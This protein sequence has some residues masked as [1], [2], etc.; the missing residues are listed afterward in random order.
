[1]YESDETFGEIFKSGEKFSKNGF[2]IHELSFQENKSCV[3]K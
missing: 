2:F 1:L 3:P